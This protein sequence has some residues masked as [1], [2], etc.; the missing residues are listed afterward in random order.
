VSG[1]PDFPL[2][3]EESTKYVLYA[4]VIGIVAAITGVIV[5]FIVNKKTADLRKQE[6]IEVM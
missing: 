5:Q 1:L 4:T 3:T 2:T 6:I